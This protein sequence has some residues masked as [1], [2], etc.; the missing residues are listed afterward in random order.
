MH[1]CNS[2]QTG[3]S[4][5]VLALQAYRSV[6]V[7]WLS[8]LNLTFLAT[9]LGSHAPVVEQMLCTNADRLSWSKACRY[10]VPIIIILF[11]WLH[12][13]AEVQHDATKKPYSAAANCEVPTLTMIDSSSAAARKV[14]FSL[15]RV[16]ALSMA[17][18][19]GLSLLALTGAMGMCC[20]YK[21]LLCN[22]MCARYGITINHMYELQMAIC[23]R[24]LLVCLR[25]DGFK[26][27]LGPEPQTKRYG[28]GNCI[29]NFRPLADTVNGLRR[30]V[31]ARYAGVDFP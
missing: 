16:S 20:I 10:T 29:I 21:Q 5:G 19:Q 22:N 1:S 9:G 2:P 14:A 26:R 8:P 18:L 23:A 13:A 6:F 25:T 12:A 30:G 4:S 15:S 7:K 17:S 28:R 3:Y 27:A 31:A 24:T 11:I